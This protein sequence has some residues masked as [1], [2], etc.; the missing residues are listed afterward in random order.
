MFR[1]ATRTTNR[2]PNM[3]CV[4]GSLAQTPSDEIVSLPLT[5]PYEVSSGPST[6]WLIQYPPMPT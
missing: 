1:A 2:V 3:K 4:W 6:Y 5:A